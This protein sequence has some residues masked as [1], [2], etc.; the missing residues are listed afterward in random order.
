[1]ISEFKKRFYYTKIYG[2]LNNLSLNKM[3]VTILKGLFFLAFLDKA[4]FS[5]L[6]Y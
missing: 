3:T 6:Y 2:E 4:Y 5:K 1:M